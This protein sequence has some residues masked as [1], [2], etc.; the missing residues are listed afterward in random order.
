MRRLLLIAMVV[1]LIV[2]VVGSIMRP[3][4]TPAQS[5]GAPLLVV[6]HGDRERGEERAEKWR[7]AAQRQGWRVLALDCPRERG[8]DE[9]GRWYMWN[10][11]PSWVREQVAALA[12]RVRIDMSR[13]FL[14][15]WSGGA[16][17]IGKK[18][19]AWASLFAGVVIH[20][21]GVAP[22]D[23]ECPARPFPAYFLVGD[24]NPAHRGS[25]RL[26]EYFERCKLDVKWDLLPGANHPLE[27]AALTPAKATEIL[28]WLEEHRGRNAE[29]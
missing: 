3:R 29:V 10:G 27:D 18:M 25:V 2:F 28:Q 19:P 20:G 22:S 9:Q 26:R 24:E 1:G 6:L 4:V 8:C 5:A 12:E 21:G 15:G 23:D 16:T 17:Y 7:E 11:S 13:V 14:V